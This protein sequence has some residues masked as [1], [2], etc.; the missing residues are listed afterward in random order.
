[1]SNTTLIACDPP[2]NRDGPNVG[3]VHAVTG[4]IA[5]E[6]EHRG[7]KVHLV[8]N[9]IFAGMDQN[10]PRYDMVASLLDK[11]SWDTIHI[12]TQSR[13]GYLVR[14]YCVERGLTFST[15]YHTQLPEYLY[16]RYGVPLDVSYDYMRWFCEPAHRVIAPTPAMAATLRHYGISNAVSCLHGVDTVNFHP[17]NDKLSLFADL[18]RPIFLFVS[19]VSPEKSPEDFLKLELPGTKIMVGGASGGLSLE[20]LQSRYPDTVFLGVKTGEELQQ[21]FRIADVF[22]FPSKTDTFGLVLLE[23]LASG[24]PVAAYPVTGPIDVI[25]DPRVGCLDFD[26]RAA[27]LRALKLSSQ[28]CRDFALQHSWPASVTEWLTHHVPARSQGLAQ[29]HKE[30]V[31][32]LMIEWLVGMTEQLLFADEPSGPYA[33]KAA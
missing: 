17:T 5:T 9:E 33:K 18:P 8:T 10:L 23:A 19:R 24:V 31:P 7:D 30:S 27:A 3:G 29:S 28:E 6:L 14:R 25:T 20:D 2:V 32:Y 4:N 16:L 21:I 26:L 13:L 11:T 15:A 1:M 22:V 12:V